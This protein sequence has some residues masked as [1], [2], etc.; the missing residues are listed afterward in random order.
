MRVVGRRHSPRVLVVGFTEDFIE[1]LVGLFPTVREVDTPTQGIRLEEW[2][3]LISES[4]SVTL[5]P[6]VYVLTLGDYLS[7]D[8]SGHELMRHGA[9]NAEELLV[10]DDLPPDIA[11]L[12]ESDL[13]PHATEQ[14]YHSPICER[15]SY[16][17]IP[18][19]HFKSA[20]DLV[21][22]FLLTGD[23]QPIAARFTREGG[24][25]ECWSLPPYADPLAW[26]EIAVRHW[27]RSAPTR[28]PTSDWLR[29]AEWRTPIEQAITKELDDLAEERRCI[30]EDLSGREA[31]LHRRLEAAV[32]EA[33]ARERHLLTER[34]DP[35]VASVS[36]AL[37]AFDFTVRNMDTEWLRYVATRGARS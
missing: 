15:V 37:Q 21:K 13:I 24:E 10:P 36:E 22:P 1:S 4:G 32:E 20:R 5:P 7:N 12:V 6:H 16:S 26:I 8:E 19:S 3:C 27:H 33:T 35:L 34:G 29:S 30:A 28:F 18:T 2:D 11:A 9:S 31:A 17:G 25:A 23:A 14:E